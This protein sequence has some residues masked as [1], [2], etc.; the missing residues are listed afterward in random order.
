MTRM[1]VRTTRAVAE[2]MYGFTPSENSWPAGWAPAEVTA[3]HPSI[4]AARR[5]MRISL[6]PWRPH[7]QYPLLLHA[8]AVEQ[9][10]HE[11]PLGLRVSLAV[12]TEQSSQVLLQRRVP[13]RLLCARAQT[14][15]HCQV[16][17]GFLRAIDEHV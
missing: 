13:G 2:R 6:R 1:W 3:T 12:V 11:R 5:L 14:I 9:L 16:S 8:R 7:M 15:T 4:T 10:A 17:A